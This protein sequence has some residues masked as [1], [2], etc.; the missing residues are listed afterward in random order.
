MEAWLVSVSEWFN[1]VRS[2]GF[3]EYVGAYK[4]YVFEL[5]VLTFIPIIGSTRGAGEISRSSLF[6]SV[7]GRFGDR[8]ALSASTA[9]DVSPGQLCFVLEVLR[10][11][12]KQH[13]HDYR[14]VGVCTQTHRGSWFHAT[15]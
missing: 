7:R 5:R 2:K 6:L 3:E 12:A 8:S 10:Q 13:F 4:L 1:G 14:I 15:D 9:S 11:L